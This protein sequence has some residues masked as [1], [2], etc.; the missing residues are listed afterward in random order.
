MALQAGQI[1]QN[2]YQ[3]IK[4][5]GKGGMGA[6]YLAQDGRLGGKSVAIKEFD[7]SILSPQDRQWAATAF[8]QE[9]HMLAQLKHPAL[10]AVSYHVHNLY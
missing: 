7:P 2:R 10:T 3:I 9:A 4:P 5:L 8:T 6:V 1:L